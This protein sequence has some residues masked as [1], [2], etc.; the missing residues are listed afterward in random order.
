MSLRSHAPRW[1][2]S[3]YSTTCFFTESP[4][5]N[6]NYLRQQ[7]FHDS[8]CAFRSHCKN[9]SALL[10]TWTTKYASEALLPTWTPEA[11]A[12]SLRRPCDRHFW[13]QPEWRADAL[14]VP[15]FIPSDTS[16]INAMPSLLSFTIFPRPLN[17]AAAA[18]SPAPLYRSCNPSSI[19]DFWS[20]WPPVMFSLY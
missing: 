15:S 14:F 16:V 6:L 17:G 10:L 18:G 1:C 2:L 3:Y 12:T 13:V 8:K 19:I 7:A 5:S 20:C 9:C 4:L 11:A